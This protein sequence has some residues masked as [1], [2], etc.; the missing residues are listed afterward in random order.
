MGN[1]STLAYD[2]GDHVDYNGLVK[3]SLH[4]GSKKVSMIRSLT[5]KPAVYNGK[6]IY[7]LTRK[8]KEK[9][10]VFSEFLKRQMQTNLS[11]RNDQFKN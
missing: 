1:A 9:V 7:R 8:S 3:W 10:L 6:N 2:I 11:W 5:D 4:A